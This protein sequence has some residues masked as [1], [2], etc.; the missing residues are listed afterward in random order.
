MMEKKGGAFGDASEVG[1]AEGIGDDSLL[2]GEQGEGEVLL[3]AELLL[4][5]NGVFGDADHFDTRGE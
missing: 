1:D 5:A 2:V 4:R 3:L